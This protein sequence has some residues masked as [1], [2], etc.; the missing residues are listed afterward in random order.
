MYMHQMGV[1]QSAFL[2]PDLG[3]NIKSISVSMEREKVRK[4]NVNA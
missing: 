1:G 2:Y 4:L 3:P